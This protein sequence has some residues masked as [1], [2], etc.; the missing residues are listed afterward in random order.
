MKKLKYRHEAILKFQQKLERAL[1][2]F[3]NQVT[4][5]LAEQEAFRM[6]VIWHLRNLL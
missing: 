6:S 5:G 3:N 4:I 1:I 2:L